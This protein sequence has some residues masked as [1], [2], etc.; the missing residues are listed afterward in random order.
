MVNKYDLE[1]KKE[2]DEF[3]EE[4]G[5]RDKW[6]FNNPEFIPQWYDWKEIFVM[7]SEY[8]NEKTVIQWKK[9]T[10]QRFVYILPNIKNPISLFHTFINSDD[11]KLPQILSLIELTDWRDLE[12]DIWAGYIANNGETITIQSSDYQIELYCQNATSEEKESK[13]V[14]P[15][16]ICLKFIH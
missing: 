16:A 7:I 3:I 9:K 5:Y 15:F 1:D 11:F 10:L 2:Y 13:S 12:Y 14:Y 8:W 4:Y 6:N